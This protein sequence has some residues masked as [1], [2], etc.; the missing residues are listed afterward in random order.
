MKKYIKSVWD[1]TVEDRRYGWDDGL[2]DGNLPELV[3]VLEDYPVGTYIMLETKTYSGH[4]YKGTVE[5]INDTTCLVDL[6]FKGRPEPQ[7]RLNFKDTA[8]ALRGLYVFSQG[9]NRSRFKIDIKES[10][11][12]PEYIDTFYV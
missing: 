8:D 5:I 4:I 3:R 6:A 2:R 11:N 7:K 12:E 1:L 10:K 9:R